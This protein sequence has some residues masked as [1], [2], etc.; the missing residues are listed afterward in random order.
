MKMTAWESEWFDKLGTE[1]MLQF[2]AEVDP[3]DQNDLRLLGHDTKEK[4]DERMM[5]VKKDAEAATTDFG[6]G[7]YPWDPVSLIKEYMSAF[8]R[9]YLDLKPCLQPMSLF[10]PPHFHLS[11]SPIDFKSS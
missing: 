3:W 8:R 6:Y 4:R 11:D 1:I 2:L 9:R 7:D 10:F 5:K